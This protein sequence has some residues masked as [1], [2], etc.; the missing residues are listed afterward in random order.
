MEFNKNEINSLE[1]FNEKPIENF[2]KL[3]NI[4][5]LSYK[6]VN[7]GSKESQDKRFENLLSIGEIKNS[8]ILD[9]GCG[10][11]DLYSYLTK[12]GKIKFY[13]GIDMTP[14]MIELSKKRFKIDQG[15]F[16]CKDILSYDCDEQYDWV[17]ASG[18]FYMIKDNQFETSLKIIKKMF[19]LSKKGIAFN[20]LSSWAI[21][22]ERGEY[23]I[24]PLKLI[25]AMRP[26]STKIKFYHNYHHSD[27]TIHLYK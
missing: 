1:S 10:I 20:S 11:G 27:F 8:S 25:E 19:E 5:G 26:L 3:A 12:I 7:W 2:T 6:S 24:D 9:V 22:K 14:K 16:E 4:H 13:K 23:Y 21:D 15:K 17:F 18:I